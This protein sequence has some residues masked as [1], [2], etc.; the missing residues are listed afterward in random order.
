MTKLALQVAII[1]AGPYGLAAAAHLRFAHAETCIFGEAMEFWQQQMPIGMFLR[2]SWEASHIADPH[3]ALTLE[4][5]QTAHG[6]KLSAPV[7]LE[8]FIKY[9]QWFQRQAAPD[10][11]RRKVTRVEAAS[12][13]FRLTLEDGEALQ[14]QRVV[15]ATGLA[16]FAY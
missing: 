12:R 1:G 5:Y 8:S 11:D 2:S 13:G 3:R 4:D 14:V 10:L 15:I 7:P 6:V 9:G 16:P